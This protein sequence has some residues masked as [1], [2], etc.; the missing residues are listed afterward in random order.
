MMRPSNWFNAGTHHAVYGIEI[1]IHG[2]WIPMGDE[3]GFFLFDTKEERD[4]AMEDH[5]ATLNA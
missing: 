5:R 1:F 3:E 4:M 2:T